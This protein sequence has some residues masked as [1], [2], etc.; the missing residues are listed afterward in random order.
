MLY[1]GHCGDYWH[2]IDVGFAEGH[3]KPADLDATPHI[4]F[5]DTSL[6]DLEDLHPWTAS[7]LRNLG[8]PGHTR[9][10]HSSRFPLCTFAYAVTRASARR[11]LEEIAASEPP[12]TGVKAYDI[13]ILLGCRDLGLRCWSVNPELF[14]H[15]PGPSMI[16]GLEN[17]AN[18]PPVDQEGWAQVQL[19]GETSNIDC[20]FWSG[21]FNFQ[22]GDVSHLEWLREEVGRKGSCIKDGR[23][24][25][26]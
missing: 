18:V 11:L 3:V 7:L 9:L 6:P 25:N 10:V 21:A 24:L 15:V 4:A 14:H 26:S 1:L 2:D 19:R 8:V 13:A 23:K 12:G 22:E 16:G 17:N 20:G 5:K